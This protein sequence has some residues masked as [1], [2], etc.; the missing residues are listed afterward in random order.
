MAKRKEGGIPRREVELEN[1]VRSCIRGGTLKLS[2]GKEWQ[3]FHPSRSLPR[4]RSLPE[5]ILR[6]RKLRAEVFF[7]PRDPRFLD[8]VQPGEI[9]IPSCGTRIY[10]TLTGWTS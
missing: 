3:R 10:T 5:A 4:G 8:P 2:D 6:G 9:T 1:V 7:L